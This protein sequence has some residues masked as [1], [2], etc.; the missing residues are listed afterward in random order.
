MKASRL[1]LTIVILTFNEELNIEACLDS[2]SG[3]NADV[4]V[5]DS[6][7]TDRTIEILEERNITYTQHAFKNYSA[8]RNW[9]HEN[10]PFHNKWV[11]PLDAGE[12]IS[13]EMAAWLNKDF[14]PADET[15][16]GYM[17]SRRTIFFD[18]WIKR[19]GHYPNYHLRLFRIGNGRCEDKI[20][21]Q[22]FVTEGN[23]Q[24]LPAGLD[25]IDTVTDNLKDFTISHARWAA[26]EA[27]ELVLSKEDSGEVNSKLTGNPIE[28]RRW[29]KNNVFQKAPLFL[30]SFL[31]FLY[32]YFIRLG[33]LD[34]KKGLVFHFLQ[35][36]WFRFLV[37]AYV[38]EIRYKLKKGMR[39]DSIAEVLGTTRIL[40][41]MRNK[42]SR[43]FE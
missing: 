22:H 31:Y 18:Q 35:G 24:S 12:R 23:V 1:P 38:L 14:N 6:F 25:I 20:Y 17:F 32:R 21:D 39:I 3:I 40:E 36:F 19:G 16:A 27:M 34:G 37:D 13:A 15:I 43:K 10:L 5:V 26:F 9:A 30:R 4:F 7:S 41:Y 8:Q 2:V 28:K 11:M 29:L 33:F 42:K